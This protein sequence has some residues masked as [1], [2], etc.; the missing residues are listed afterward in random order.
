M[1]EIKI[2]DDFIN[3]LI[4][5]YNM[6][7]IKFF[8]EFLEGEQAVLFA[9]KF[10]GLKTASELSE[11]LGVT[12]SRLT[13]VINNLKRKGLV[14]IVPN[15]FDKR[16]KDIYLTDR[17]IEFIILKEE[18]AMTLFNVYLNKMSTE[19]IILFTELLNE[20]VSIMKE[21]KFND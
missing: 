5:I 16:I 6:K 15:N 19:K 2:K 3:A 13:K 18:A 21:V 8:L 11:K 14:K 4:N 1:S 7:H 20:T 17:G 10:S 12:K 9:L